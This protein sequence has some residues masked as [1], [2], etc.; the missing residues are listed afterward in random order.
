MTHHPRLRVAAAAAVWLALWTPPLR[1]WLESTMTLHMLVQLS[2]LVL[3]GWWWGGQ[4]LRHRPGLAHRAMAYRAPLGLLAVGTFTVWM[5]P[6]LLDLASASL[7]V[8]G[9]K[10]V[11]LTL[12]GGLAWRLSWASL[13]PVVRGL[14]HLEALATLWR[15]S[16]LY[17]VS[18]TRLCVQYRLDDQ[19]RLG[20][21]LAVL[22]VAYALYLVW[23]PLAGGLRFSPKGM[24]HVR[25]EH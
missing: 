18:P 2:A 10:A 14:L 24:W 22:G 19:A 12:L 7:W 6:R 25:E 4:A 5:I 3:V 8:D 9:L 11:S 21:A 16:W 20:Q 15:L 1:G 17:L 13:G 23:Q